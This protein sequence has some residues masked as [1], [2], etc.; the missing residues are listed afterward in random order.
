MHVYIY[1]IQDVLILFLTECEH[2][3]RLK[4]N[5]CDVYVCNSSNANFKLKINEFQQIPMINNY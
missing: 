5:L 2:I 1:T 4:Q 3:F